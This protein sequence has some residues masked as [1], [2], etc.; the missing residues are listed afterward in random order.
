MCPNSNSG[1]FFR[2]LP[3]LGLLFTLVCFQHVSA[4]MELPKTALIIVD[5]QNDFCAGGPMAIPQAD[6]VI[7]IINHLRSKIDFGIVVFTM[8]WHPPNHIS[9]Y[10][11]F[12]NK[13]LHP[14]AKLR[15]EYTFD[16]GDGRGERKQILWPTHCVQNTTGA[17]LR[18]GLK[19]EKNDE[20]VYKGTEPDIDSY[21][22]FLAND[23]LTETELDAVLKK[24]GI[25]EIIVSGL[26]F[27][28]CVGNTAIDGVK[29]GYGVTVLEDGTGSFYPCQKQ[30]YILNL[31]NNGV[32]VRSSSEIVNSL[33]DMNNSK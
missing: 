5:V 29:M 31:R 1:L 4:K 33:E 17:Q 8:D 12:S 13:K 11:R 14:N 15:E 7:P 2:L 18:V 24:N 10:E 23:G 26:A 6:E 28:Y 3:I 22:G 21:S 30:E 9:F 20:I 19:R 25:E 16:L 27:E 32:S